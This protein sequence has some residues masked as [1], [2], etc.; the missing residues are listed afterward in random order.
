MT[1]EVGHDLETRGSGSSRFRT[2][3]LGDL[4]YHARRP[5]FAVWA[6]DPGRSPPGDF[7]AGAC[8]SSRAT[9][10]LGAPRPTSPPSLPWPCSSRIF[11][12]L[13]YGFFISVAAGMT[14]IQDEEWRL[15]DL[16]HATPL[17][18][19][20]YIWAKFAA[21]LAGC[22]II[23]GI[24]LA[25]TA[26]F[27]HVLPNAQAQE[28]RGPFH[29]LNYLKPALV[30]SV[31][32][33]VF[34]AGV[35]FAVGEWTR[36]PVL[37]FLLPVAIVVLDG[38]FLWEWSPSWLDP[39][40]DYALMLIDSAG[41]RW[42]NETWL[43]VDRGVN[44]YNNAAIPFDT[45]FPDQPGGL[46]WPGLARRGSQP[47]SFHREAARARLTHGPDGAP[48]PRRGRSTAGRHQAGRSHWDRWA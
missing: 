42:L 30:F 18:P 8:G 46:H 10:R 32:T 3:F 19:G 7:R 5:L 47:P 31:P 26:F 38:F 1:S 25:A 17:R 4:I 21:V 23:L 34:L 2:V 22:L 43:K 37:V 15:G 28:F 12:T 20:E 13:F 6:L 11:T 27:Y 33:I 16:L 9:R 41:F 36:R 45:G 44:F 14:I 39:R 40:I 35:S 24:H 29:V 48:S